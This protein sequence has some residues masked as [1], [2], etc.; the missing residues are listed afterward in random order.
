MDESTNAP[1]SN[2]H[3]PMNSPTPSAWQQAE[4]DHMLRELHAY[5]RLT[6]EWDLRYEKMF[7][8]GALSKWYSSVGNEATTV[9]CGSAIGKG[10]ALVS[11]HRDVG[12]ILRHYVN[13]EELFPD[14]FPEKMSLV[15]QPLGGDSRDR[16][17]R[18]ACQMLGREHGFSRGHERSYHYNHMEPD[19]GLIHLGMISHLGSMIPVAAGAALSFQQQGLDR[20][21]INFIGEGATSTGDFHE[22]LNIAAVWKL[23]FIL[24]I[25][26]NH[27]AF[28]TPTSQ[29]YAC[30]NLA[31]R[32]LG[33]GIPG[34]EVDGNDPL[35]VLE[36]MQT[37]VKRAR[38]G[39]GPTLVEAHLGRHR[40]HSEGDDSL[41]QVPSDE[42]KG[43]LDNDPM[44]LI[45]ARLLSSGVVSRAWL[46]EIKERSANLIMEVVDEAMAMPE[47]TPNT[48]RNTYAD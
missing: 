13:I 24:V 19:H 25:E 4:S 41:N 9:A 31:S 14:I 6:R 27:W 22:G 39:E 11:L 21:S 16:L 23:P 12:A 20:V 15:R 34:V 28:S 3:A 40:G 26:N 43:Y 30:D 47:P 1:S 45:E 7:K 17:F 29:Q 32:A 35:A 44:D 37:A 33:Y 18:L 5:M 2:T 46:Q 10:D 8:T 38:A 42:L 36:V 48:D